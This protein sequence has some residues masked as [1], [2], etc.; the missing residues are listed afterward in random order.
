[1]LGE[2]QVDVVQSALRQMWIVA[3]L[4]TPCFHQDA[5]I[6][7]HVAGGGRGSFEFGIDPNLDAR[8]HLARD[9]SLACTDP[10]ALSQAA[11]GAALRLASTPSLMP[12]LTAHLISHQHA[13][14]PNPL[15]QAAAGAALSLASTP[16]CT[17]TLM[18][19]L[20]SHVT[21]LLSMD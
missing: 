11:A 12:A 5:L 10:K 1:M 4:R 3:L 2:P 6:Q 7:G 8:T 16:T 20:T 9:Q 17:P 19:A 18:P 13:L 14:T 15:S 21:N